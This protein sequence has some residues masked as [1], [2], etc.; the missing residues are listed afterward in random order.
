MDVALTVRAV[1][2]CWC[3]RSVKEKK[4]TGGRDDE[5]KANDG[6]AVW[7]L[8]VVKVKGDRVRVADKVSSLQ[9]FLIRESH[10]VT[11]EAVHCQK[12][13]DAASTLTRLARVFA[14]LPPADDPAYPAQYLQLLIDS[15]NALRSV[16][17]S[18]HL[19][20]LL[21]PVF[22]SSFY[23]APPLTP[24]FLSH[25]V[26][27]T[28]L[29]RCAVWSMSELLNGRE[30]QLELHVPPGRHITMLKEKMMDWQIQH[31]EEV[32]Q[33]K[34]GKEEALAHLRT[35]PLDSAPAPG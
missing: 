29:F 35:I 15:A 11:S 8:K 13:T 4:A 31:I 25:L 30:V 34:V 7:G 12:I 33:G 27:A 3:V 19:A 20:V 18:H 28:P 10:I 1:L 9:S 22:E 16:P 14:S 17:T 32:T 23:P 21:T 26:D 6:E 5:G 2:W 24:P